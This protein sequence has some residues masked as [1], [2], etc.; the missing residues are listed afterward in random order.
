MTGGR[1]LRRGA[2]DGRGRRRSRSAQLRQLVALGRAGHR[3]PDGAPAAHAARRRRAA[4]GRPGDPVA[5]RPRDRQP[6][7]GGGAA[8]AR[9]RVGQRSRC[10]PRRLPRAWRCRRRT[11]RPTPSNAAAKAHAVARRDGPA[12]ARPTIRASRSMRSAARRACARRASR[13]RTRERIAQLLAA[14]ARRH[15]SAGPLPLRR[16]ARLA[17]RPRVERPRGSARGA[18]AG[19]AEGSGGFGYDPVFVADE[20][21]RTFAAATAAEKARVSHRARAVRALGARLGVASVAASRWRRARE[22]SL[23]GGGG[24]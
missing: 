23:Y 4:A 10:A 16:R 9:A 15:G 5:P 19:R 3:A 24:A 2:G 20:L 13:R 21:G 8:R 12:R 6:G 1:P 17:R 11:A 18:I 14:L 22:P 7:Q